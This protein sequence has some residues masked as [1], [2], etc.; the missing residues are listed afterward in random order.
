M[1]VSIMPTEIELD[2]TDHQIFDY[3]KKYLATRA[4]TY[5]CPPRFN[6]VLVER[7]QIHAAQLFSLFGMRD[8]GRFDGWILDNGETF[9]SDFNPVSGMEQNSFLF[10][11]A[12]R[13]GMTHRDVLTY[14]VKNACRRHGIKIS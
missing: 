2:Y 5:H 9:F 6:S 4:V 3:R 7:I 13:I 8:F 10:M 11:Q 1:P 12:A 14:V